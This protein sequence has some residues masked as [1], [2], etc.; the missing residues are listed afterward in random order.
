MENHIM[1]AVAWA[2][3]PVEK[4]PA[5]CLGLAAPLLGG[6]GNT[7]GRTQINGLARPGVPYPSADGEAG[8]GPVEQRRLPSTLR[9]ASAGVGRSQKAI[10]RARR[11]SHLTGQGW[12]PAHSY[13]T[14]G[15]T[16]NVA[17]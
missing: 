3:K 8:R 5:H 14:A 9:S 13:S 7:R 2:R 17:P 16:G 1:P 11:Q 15:P 4:T 10:L 6:T 12:R